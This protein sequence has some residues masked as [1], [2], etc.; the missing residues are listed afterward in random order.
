MVVSQ[1]LTF[2]RPLHHHPLLDL[3][4]RQCARFL[5]LDLDLPEQDLFIILHLIIL[6]D[7]L[8]HHIFPTNLVNIIWEQHPAYD[9]THRYAVHYNYNILIFGR[10]FS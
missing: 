10:I 7:L 6:T 3:V 1:H 5:L 2:R 9:L 4:N 8:N